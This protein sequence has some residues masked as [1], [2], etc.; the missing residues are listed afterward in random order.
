M[1]SKKHPQSGRSMVEILGVLAIIAVLTVG[2]LI[3]YSR[4]MAKNKL[5]QFVN[6]TN[7]LSVNLASTL[8]PA[9]FPAEG[10]TQNITAMLSGM[11]YLPVKNPFKGVTEVYLEGTPV[12][13]RK[14]IV[15]IYY[16]NISAFACKNLAFDRPDH[17]EEISI[18]VGG[19]VVATTELSDIENWNAWCDDLAK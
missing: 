10:V 13:E 3:G 17:M 8:R 7:L 18:V 5:N 1:E 11:G 9:D 14:N 4:A 15:N 19:N 16:S 2:G 12:G 6:E